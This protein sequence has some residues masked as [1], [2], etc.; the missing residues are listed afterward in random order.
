MKNQP[1]SS[2]WQ[3]TSQWA[4]SSHSPALR[5]SLKVCE[6]QHTPVDTRQDSHEDQK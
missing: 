3:V 1:F 4:D 6:M 2:Y 5:I